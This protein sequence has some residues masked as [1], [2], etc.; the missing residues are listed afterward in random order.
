MALHNLSD[1]RDRISF[2]ENV[3]GEDIQKFIDN[4]TFILQERLKTYCN[5]VVSYT[6]EDYF[7]DVD[8]VFTKSRECYSSLV[9]ANKNI[10]SMLRCS[11]M[12]KA[13]YI[14]PY[15][16]EWFIDT[17]EDYGF[18]TPG[19]YFLPDSDKWKLHEEVLLDHLEDAIV[20]DLHLRKN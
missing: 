7:D 5:F 9:D 15:V 19:D 20:E 17:F 10:L 8:D 16:K 2:E 14:F 3:E 18:A 6:L 11:H 13:D 4:Y 1:L 12:F